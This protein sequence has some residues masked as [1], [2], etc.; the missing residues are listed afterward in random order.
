MSQLKLPKIDHQ[1]QLHAYMASIMLQGTNK[2]YM[3]VYRLVKV[4][5]QAERGPTWNNCCPPSPIGP[6]HPFKLGLAEKGS[7]RGEGSRAAPPRQ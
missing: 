2:P 5:E 7:G 3:C 6:C 4:K 1:K